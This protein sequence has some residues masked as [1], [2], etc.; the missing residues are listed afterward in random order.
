MFRASSIGILEIHI[1]RLYFILHV[2]LGQ[3]SLFDFLIFYLFLVQDV[4]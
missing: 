2:I 1:V 3:A 4:L